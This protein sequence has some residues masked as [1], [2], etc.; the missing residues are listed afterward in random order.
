[1]GVYQLKVLFRNVG[2][3]RPCWKVKNRLVSLQCSSSLCYRAGIRVNYYNQFNTNHFEL[4]I[5]SRR[6]KLCLKPIILLARI[7]NNSFFYSF[8][9]DFNKPRRTK[10][11]ALWPSQVALSQWHRIYIGLHCSENASATAAI[12]IGHCPT[13]FVAVK[14]EHVLKTNSR[15]NRF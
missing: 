3:H 11:S 12:T 14:F 7:F 2:I 4:Y 5:E 6:N 15:R 10:R 9:L 8:W 13:A 1:M